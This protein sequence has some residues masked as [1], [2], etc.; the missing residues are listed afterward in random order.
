[1]AE[2]EDNRS[3][4]NELRRQNPADNLSHADRVRG[5][6]RSSR[7]QRRDGQGQF[8][9]RRSSETD[10]QGT[11]SSSWSAQ[12]G[13]D[14]GRAGGSTGQMDPRGASEGGLQS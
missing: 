11:E 1:M 6:E 12:G 9:G 3:A 2:N 7:M 13:R 8:A 14:S 5:G 4:S 10:P